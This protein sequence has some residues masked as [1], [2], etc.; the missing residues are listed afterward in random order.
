LLSWTWTGVDGGYE[1]GIIDAGFG[2]EAP[3]CRPGWESLIAVSYSGGDQ[4][5]RM[6][7][8]SPASRTLSHFL[9]AAGN[10]APITEIP[11]TYAC[12]VSGATSWFGADGGLLTAPFLGFPIRALAPT[13]GLYA[14]VPLDAGSGLNTPF[15]VSALDG[16]SLVLL[17]TFEIGTHLGYF[18][19]HEL[20]GR[21]L[22]AT[23]PEQIGNGFCPNCDV[24]AFVGQYICA[25]P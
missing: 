24:Q 19:L 15:G 12:Q 3:S 13:R 7:R 20:G 25:P 23:W 14:T 18:R 22:L 21:L 16:G 8:F 5:T 2:P 1:R 10:C 9:E 6:Q 17:T 4:K 11:F